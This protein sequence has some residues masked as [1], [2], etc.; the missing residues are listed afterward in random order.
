MPDWMS[1]SSRDL[2]S[3]LHSEKPVI[4]NIT[5]Q[6]FSYNDW[7]SPG[8]TTANDNSRAVTAKA[9]SMA[10]VRV[11]LLSAV[12]YGHV[13]PL[14]QCKSQLNHLKRPIYFQTRL[15]TTS[16]EQQ[17]YSRP[18]KHSPPWLV[19]TGASREKEYAA[20]FRHEISFYK[21]GGSNRVNVTEP[22]NLRRMK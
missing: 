12:Q 6:S 5:R 15:C 3:R 9:M 19:S 17:E 11:F 20:A 4:R 14:G 8:D 22:F 1:C 13:S 18:N 2:Q 21:R 10:V 7:T 16:P